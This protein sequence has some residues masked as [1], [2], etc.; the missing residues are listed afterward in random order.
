MLAS[1]LIAR[2]VGSQSAPSGRFLVLYAAT[3]APGVAASALPETCPPPGASLVHA[4][5]MATTLT[6]WAGRL[7]AAGI[8]VHQE[9]AVARFLGAQEAPVFGRHPGAVTTRAKTLQFYADVLRSAVDA[10]RSRTY[11]IPAASWQGASVALTEATASATAFHAAR[12]ALDAPAQTWPADRPELAH[13]AEQQPV[14]DRKMLEQT[15]GRAAAMHTTA[16]AEAIGCL[17]VA[18]GGP[19]LRVIQTPADL[20]AMGQG[21][22]VGVEVA[23]GPLSAALA[24]NLDPQHGGG[25]FG[26]GHQPV[27]ALAAC[28]AA[29]QVVA[30]LGSALPMT[31]RYV[32]TRMDPDALVA[33]MILSGRIPLP[34]AVAAQADIAELAELDSSRPVAGGWQPGIRKVQ[35]V[36]DH[37]F[38]G[39]VGA[40]CLSY[41]RGGDGAATLSDLEAAV[42]AS[43]RQTTARLAAEQQ[44]ILTAWDRADELAQRVQV[45]GV[46]ASGLNFPI[47]ASTFAVLYERAPIGVLVADAFPFRSPSGTVTGR[48]FTVACSRDLG[49]QGAQFTSAFRRLIVAQ[50]PGWGGAATIT[51][52]PMSGPSK[53]DAATVLQFAQKAAAEVGIVGATASMG[54]TAPI[55][56]R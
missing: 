26:L 45:A 17:R 31:T 49:E 37:P 34:L 43:L 1:S 40:L 48:K 13:L 41:T 9:G 27:G 24:A 36:A 16:M 22:I 19:W 30:V 21:L 39:A 47:G 56:L 52:S 5:T 3:F 15:V 10:S 2:F 29:V 50:E 46:V 42:L 25:T 20:S 14:Q 55:T 35:T 28:D 54:S 6:E 38:W 53:L 51:G 7:D 8:Q 18:E 12:A 23:S 33:A 4:R 44:R 32:T 11:Q